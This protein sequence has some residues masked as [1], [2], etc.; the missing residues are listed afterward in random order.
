MIECPYC[1]EL[2]REGK[3]CMNCGQLIDITSNSNNFQANNNNNYDD[4]RRPGGQNNNQQ[5]NQQNNN[6]NNQQSNPYNQQNQYQQPNYQTP[7][8]NKSKFIGF[9]LNFFLPGLG[10]GY[11]DFWKEAILY[12][13]V[14]Y[15]IWFIGIFLIIPWI[16]NLA[17]WIYAFIDVNKQID[18][19]NRGL[20][21]DPI[22]FINK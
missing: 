4:I 21:L 17:M 5:Y 11:L 3:F 1:H 10:Y 16:I 18:N 15:V 7:R 19:Y 12:I 13:V 2:T 9:I 14:Y 20:K 6:Y 22:S 8:G